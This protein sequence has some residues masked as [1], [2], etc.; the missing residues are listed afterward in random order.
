MAS[1]KFFNI[2]PNMTSDS[3]QNWFANR[4]VEF[5][6]NLLPKIGSAANTAK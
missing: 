3:I 4:A 2:D 6:T 1:E 5:W